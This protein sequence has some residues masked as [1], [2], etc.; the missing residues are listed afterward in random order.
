MLYLI[1][2]RRE[3]EERLGE[4]TEDM[5]RALEALRELAEVERIAAGV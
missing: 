5:R 3:L 2:R 1:R 4:I